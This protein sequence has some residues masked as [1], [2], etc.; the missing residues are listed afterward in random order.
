LRGSRKGRVQYYML[1]MFVVLLMVLL[2]GLKL[3]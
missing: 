3:V 2:L 1:S